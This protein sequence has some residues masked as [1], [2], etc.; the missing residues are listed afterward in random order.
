MLGLGML[1]SRRMQFVVRA[2]WA[3]FVATGCLGGCCRNCVARPDSLKRQRSF[4]KS[5]HYFAP[6]FVAPFGFEDDI[7]P[8]PTQQVL[9]S[10]KLGSLARSQ[11]YCSAQRR[12]FEALR[13]SSVNFVS[14][15]H[16]L[17]CP[18]PSSTHYSMQNA[19]E[20]TVGI[21]TAFILQSPA[22]AIT[23]LSVSRPLQSPQVPSFP[24]SPSPK[25]LVLCLRRSHPS[26]SP[27]SRSS[28]LASHPEN[29][30]RW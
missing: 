27:I 16:S 1:Q 28:P 5:R 7:L 10:H 22:P 13:V 20:S 23:F 6:L 30:C 3:Q 29:L 19:S 14:R 9:K 17:F 21:S 12:R 4:G 11:L 15:K 24:E 8:G 2:S 25:S 26:I 18:Q